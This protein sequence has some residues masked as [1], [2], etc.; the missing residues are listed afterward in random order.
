MLNSLLEQ[1]LSEARRL[2]EDG[3]QAGY[4]A[5]VELTGLRDR[6]L[7][8]VE[9]NKAAITQEQKL[10]I[11]ELLE[12]DPIIMQH[13]LEL[14]VE[15]EAGIQRIQHSHRQRDAYQPSYAADSVMFDRK[16]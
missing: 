2:S 10:R 15:A 6:L 11:R 1:V 13:M 7:E 8:A 4:E 3:P 16:K 14:K 9:Q 12:L 5:F